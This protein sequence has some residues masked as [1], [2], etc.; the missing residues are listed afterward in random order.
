[1]QALEVCLSSCCHNGMCC[2]LF[3]LFLLEKYFAILTLFCITLAAHFL[4]LECHFRDLS[5]N[6]IG[7]SIP[8]SLPVT[9]RELYVSDL[10]TF[11]SLLIW[12]LS[13]DYCHFLS[14]FPNF[15]GSFL[16]ANQLTGSIPDSLS[17][18]TL[19]SDM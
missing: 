10:L 8:D 13:N 2:F 7:G 3:Y 9:I 6:R 17:E 16:S 12:F 19:L 14:F 18:L 4:F 5:N 11:F 15:C 1:M